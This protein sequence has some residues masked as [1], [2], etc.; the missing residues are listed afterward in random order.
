[1]PLQLLHIEE[2]GVIQSSLWVVVA[3]KH[4]HLAVLIIDGACE[5]E[6]LR[7]GNGLVFGVTVLLEPLGLR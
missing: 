2:P 7:S 1:M 3:S 5:R 4:E 6:V